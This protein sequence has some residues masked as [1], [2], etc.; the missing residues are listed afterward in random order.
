MILPPRRIGA[1]I[2]AGALAIPVGAGFCQDEKPKAPA[3]PAAPAGVETEGAAQLIERGRA[4]FAKN[5]FAEAEQAL[6]KFIDD[7]GEAEEAE[8]AVKVLTPLV[9]ISKVG[10]KKFDEALVWI[11]KSLAD[12]QL[13][14]AV[15]DELS[16]WKAICLM[17]DKDKLV[18][19]QE[20]FGEY[21]ANENHNAFKRYEALL[22]FATLYLQ[23]DFPEFAADFLAGEIPKFREEAP[24]AASRAVVLQL[25]SRIAAK[26]D[27]QALELIKTEY[28]RLED[29]TQVI[30]FQML[31]LQLGAKFLEEKEWHNAIACLQR[32]WTR[33]KL[34]EYQNAKV[35]QIEDRIA[36]LKKRPNTQSTIFQLEA[37]L[38]RVNRELDNFQKQENFNSALRLRLA[39]AFQGL[40]RYR[41]AALVMEDMLKSMP[42]D[43]VVDSASL[44]L[45]QCWMEIERWPKAIEAADL[46]VEKFGDAG[47]NLATVLFLKAEALRES[48]AHGR[49]QLAY[50]ELVEKFPKDPIAPKAMF[51]QGF[52]YLQQ[53]DNEGAIYQFEQLKRQYPDSPM[54]DDGD[55]WTGQ[56]LGFS[57]EYVAARE[58]MQGYLERWENP[59]YEK[60]ALFRI[61]VCT[62]S[63]AEYPKSIE[64]F[65]SWLE[66]YE[67][68]SLADEVNLLLGDACFGEGEAEKGFAAY[69]RVRPSGGRFFEDAWFK[70]GNAI[71]LLEE[72]D[73]M[74][75]HFEE[76]ITKFPES[77]RMPE[78][79]Y[80]VGWVHTSRGEPEKAREIYWETI[81][82]HGND[83]E[84]YTMADL[85]DGLPSVYKSDS[86]DGRQALLTRLEST[87][88]AAKRE[89]K[90]TLA[91]RSLWQ[92]AKIIGRNAPETGRVELQLLA[93]L[94]D[95]KIH[96]PLISTAVADALREGGNPIK[97]KEI[98][99][100]TRKWHPRAV[101]K[102]RIYRGLGAIAEAEGDGAKAIEY[103]EKFEKETAA[104]TGLGEIQLAKA[105]IYGEQGRAG[106]ARETLEAVLEGGT[107]TAAVKAKA[108]F[109][110]GR[111][112]EEE[113]DLK[114]AT[115]Y[116]ERVYVAYGKFSEL[117]AKAYW[118][119]GEALEELNMSPEALEVY[120]ELAARDDLRRF[121]EAE[122][123]EAK[124]R[125]LE[126]LVPK[127]PQP[128]SADKGGKGEAGT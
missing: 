78:A 63:N 10:V 19:A 49:A 99:T 82:A 95:P 22:M 87:A 77:N 116:Y 115:A 62:F 80:W 109:D 30:S 40:G 60:E 122:K 106:K 72:Y 67:G 24:E 92:R 47:T 42:Q 50:G 91:L 38:K 55:Y 101:Q 104:S 83:P 117:N 15:R 81:D 5:N 75:A 108:L 70:K 16:F 4:A 102:D 61:A 48:H 76:Y 100:E 32:I 13:D 110:I 96:N 6:E 69:E 93:D 41:E 118:A 89:G 126:P 25:Y 74:Q 68:D 124:I 17:T 3:D 66:T 12:P 34:L 121:D 7:Y 2:L 57:S 120:R 26:Q 88:S 14:F 125:R 1:L 79:V 45:L 39:M 8:K 18:E 86:E 46:Y 9:A 54:L 128:E 43:A 11:E 23:Q 97:A 37:I 90:N 94:V 112:L 119:R 65:E 27:E 59:K 105:R 107:V 29:M 52:L 64:Q 127:E 31:A 123:A 113:G 111:I 44:A 58:H 51:M 53:D 33:E 36:L 21:W 56:A 28:P 85:L 20:A 114:K 98:Y 35:K 73:R 71:K 103:Y 84:M